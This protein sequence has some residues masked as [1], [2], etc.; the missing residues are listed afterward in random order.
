MDF[1]DNI[2]SRI[3]GVFSEDGDELLFFILVFAY[4]FLSNTRDDY[5]DEPEERDNS[6][7]LFFIV[8]LLLLFLNNDRSEEE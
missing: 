1:L 8:L 4:L 7:K 5:L 2:V 6:S 3:K